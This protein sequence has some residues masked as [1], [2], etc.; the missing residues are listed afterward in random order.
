MT[1]VVALRPMTYNGV[2]RYKS[3]IFTLENARNDA[4][5]ISTHLLRLFDDGEQTFTADNLGR[6]FT[7]ESAVE[8]AQRDAD[9]DTLHINSKNKP[10]EKQETKVKKS[11]GRP[12]GSKDTK[13]RKQRTTAAA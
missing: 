9:L 12:K 8:S 2:K 6:K 13:K 7:V 1:D 4:T 3:E 11:P 10:K 5:L